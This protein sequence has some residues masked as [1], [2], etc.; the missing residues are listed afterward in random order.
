MRDGPDGDFPNGVLSGL[1]HGGKRDMLA[2]KVPWVSESRAVHESFAG[3]SYRVIFLQS[4]REIIT[5]A[6][7]AV[8]GFLASTI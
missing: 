8:C 7:C 2:G 5:K 3:D 1:P 6:S 4:W